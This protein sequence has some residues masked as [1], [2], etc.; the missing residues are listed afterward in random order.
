M[1][2]ITRS[3]QKLEYLI[4]YLLSSHIVDD[5]P[6]YVEF[7]K[8]YLK[9]FD[10]SYYKYIINW[11]DNTNWLKIYSEFLSDTYPKRTVNDYEPDGIIPTDVT[12][13]NERVIADDSGRTLNLEEFLSQ[14]TDSRN[15]LY[16]FFQN[17]FYNVLDPT[18]TKLEN[19]QQ[20]LYIYL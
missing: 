13:Y 3:D 14:S 11:L 2:E 6:E 1:A 15:L 12:E 5:Y 10:E 8:L 4:Q 20:R 7:I 16:Y 17:Y 18:T 19:E 9:Y